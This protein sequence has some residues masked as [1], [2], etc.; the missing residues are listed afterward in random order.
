VAK[1]KAV[2]APPRM[3]A[4]DREWR[5]RDDMRVLIES[6]KIQADRARLKAA[7][8]QARKEAEALRR[9]AAK[10]AKPSGR[11]RLKDDTPI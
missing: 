5:A 9:V 1:G 2:P 7:Q 4:S 6:Q 10:P 3:S 11:P 8:E